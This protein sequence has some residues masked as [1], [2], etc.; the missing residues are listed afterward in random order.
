[1][2]YNYSQVPLQRPGPGEWHDEWSTFCDPAISGVMPAAAI[3]FRQGHI[4][5]AR[6]TYC[7]KL[8]PAQLFETYLDPTNTATVRTLAEQSRLTIGIPAVKELPWLKPS[9]LPAGVKVVTDPDH[10]F[11]PA[12]QSFVRS[13]TGE[14][15][16]SWNEGIQTID[17]PKTQAVSG[18][19]GGKSFSLED[20]TFEFST[21]KAVVALTSIDG[22]PL[23]TS[24]FILVTAIAQARSAPPPPQQAARRGAGHILKRHSVR[25]RAGRRRDHAPDQ[26]H[27]SRIAVAGTRRQ[28]RQPNHTLAQPGRPLDHPASRPRHP[29][30]RAHGQPRRPSRQTPAPAGE[31]VRVI[32]VWGRET[33]TMP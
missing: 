13:D 26:D 18:W 1:M 20:A 10:D 4:S 25:V 14:L 33:E 8:S 2:I 21:R 3:A 24:R 27:R 32:C 12:G 11:I 29:L 28:G 17:T 23:A 5:P 16:R 31:P 9:E 15:T 19:I 22:E 7:L 6:E 30:V